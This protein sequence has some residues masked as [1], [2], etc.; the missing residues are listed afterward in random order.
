MNFIT[1]SAVFPS[2]DLCSEETLYFRVGKQCKVQFGDTNKI[3]MFK[4][5]QVNTDT[6]FNSFSIGKWKNHTALTDLSLNLYFKGKVILKWWW[7]RTQD[8]HLVLGETVLS[9]EA[10]N[11]V[12]PVV[13]PHYERLTDGV[14]SFELFALEDSELFDFT[15]TTSMMPRREVKLGIVITHFNRQQ[16]VI[17]AVDRLNKQL[18]SDSRYE[19]I[20]KLFVVDNSQNLKQEEM[21]GA[22]VIPNANLGGSGGFMRGLIHVQD[23]GGFTHCLFMDD[24]ASNEIE[25]IRRMISLLQYTIDPMTAVAGAMLLEQY[26]YIQHENGAFFKGTCSPRN[27]NFD[28]KS[29]NCIVNNEK[30]SPFDYAGWWFCAFP[31]DQV[32]NYTFPFFV[33][34]DDVY[35]GL[36]NEFNFITL[37]GISSW[38]ESFLV[39]DSPFTIYLDYRNHLV[40]NLL[41]T[42]P[43]SSKRKSLT[44]LRNWVKRYARTYHYEMA[45]AVLEALN[46]VMKGPDFWYQNVNMT[47]RRKQ[48]LSQVKNETMRDLPA[49]WEKDFPGNTP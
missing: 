5:G 18:L 15:Y 33:R 9:S 17:P 35:F 16:Y 42:F 19:N 31:L 8:R 11:Q 2:Y 1:Q 40:H 4:G 22:Q 32:K 28:M 37:N 43:N 41:K 6:Y 14:L 47:E 30:E 27:N 48:I 46:D 10:A 21:V 7:H 29:I 38:Q 3:V 26:P 25:A 12:V 49:G 23:M 24:D 36:K 34:G 39:K 20:V 44:T 13:V 45:N